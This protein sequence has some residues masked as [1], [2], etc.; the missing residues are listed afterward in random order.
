ME[1]DEDY[2]VSFL[3][4][5]QFLICLKN[6]YKRG[7]NQSKLSLCDTVYDSAKRQGYEIW[8]I[9]TKA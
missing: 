5:M 1:R 2:K 9:P 7:F 3:Q 8:Q 6:E 4:G